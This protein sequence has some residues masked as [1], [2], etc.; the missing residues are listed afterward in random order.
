ML[1]WTVGFLTKRK[2]SVVVQGQTLEQVLVTYGVPQG[3]VLDPV[4]FLVHM[5]DITHGIN[6]AI[7]TSF[8]DNTEVWRGINNQANELQLQHEMNQIYVWSNTNNM[9]FNSGK[10][11]AIRFQAI[12]DANHNNSFDYTASDGN[13]IEQVQNVKDLG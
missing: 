1:K 11:Q 10:F 3:S 12:N 5:Y 8:A 7:I 13:I 2:Q 6:E 9:E 4:L